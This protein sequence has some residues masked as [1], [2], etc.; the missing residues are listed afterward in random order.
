MKKNILFPEDII[1]TTNNF[2][3][4]QDWEIPIPGFFILAPLR[5]IKSIT[6]F[7]KD[8]LSE[9]IDI[10]QKIRF[11]MKDV[12]NID[13]VYFFQNEDTSHNFHLWIFPRY[14]WMNKFGFGIQSV[15]PIMNYAKENMVTDLVITEVKKCVNKMKIYLSGF[16]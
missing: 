15:K 12:L 4:G 7:T 11:G 13:I 14:E 1:I 3:V 2:S 6:E 5:K 8:E 9:Y 16:R 10:T